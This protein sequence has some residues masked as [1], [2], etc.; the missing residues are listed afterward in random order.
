M[1]TTLYLFSLRPAEKRWNWR[2]LHA[3]YL[4]TTCSVTDWWHHQHDYFSG[5]S[6]VMQWHA[7]S[8]TGRERTGSGM[9]G[10][11]RS[12]EQEAGGAGGERF[13]LLTIVISLLCCSDRLLSGSSSSHGWCSLIRLVL[14][15]YI[16]CSGLS[17]CSTWTRLDYLCRQR[18]Y[19]TVVRFFFRIP[20]LGGKDLSACR[21]RFITHHHSEIAPEVAKWENCWATIAS[22]A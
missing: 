6:C 3:L 14:Y 16:V 17:S 20:V 11:G 18:H 13:A 7:T 12:C 8:C 9:Q 10:Q 1:C 22:F 4:T 19:L 21:V 2:S 15:T 5:L